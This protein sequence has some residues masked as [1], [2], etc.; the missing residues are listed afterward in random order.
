MEL[1]TDVLELRGVKNV[2]SKKGNTYYYL[3]CENVNDGTPYQ[4]YCPDPKV[5]PEGLKKGDKVKVVVFYNNFKN[6]V[7]REVKKV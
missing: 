5:F 2:A 4:F 3:N 7:V 1:L 6:L